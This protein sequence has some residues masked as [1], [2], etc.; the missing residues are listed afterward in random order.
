MGRHFLA[1][2]G[3]RGGCHHDR[4]FE[5]IMNVT[6]S[7]PVSDLRVEASSGELR[8]LNVGAGSRATGKLHPAFRSSRWIETRLDI[9]PAVAPDIVSSVTDLSYFSNNNFDAIWS[10]HNIEHLASHE[11]PIA[12]TE[13]VRVLRPGGFALITCPDLEQVATALI[14][15]GPEF[16]A[17][18]SPSG[19][20]TPLDML[21]GHRRSIAAGSPYMAHRTGFTPEVIARALL[22]A[23]FKEVRVMPGT[24]YDLWALALVDNDGLASHFLRE[25]AQSPLLTTA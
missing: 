25:T 24:F 13:F 4:A 20:I 21:F 8:V 5:R 10:S 23:G 6:I 9:D 12:L 15:G 16:V 3:P 22:D 1:W 18:H 11:V 2:L 17:Y 19:P 7:G 14:D